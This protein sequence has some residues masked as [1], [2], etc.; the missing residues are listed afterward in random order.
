M[1]L[2]VGQL[3]LQRQIGKAK[4]GVVVADRSQGAGLGTELV[5]RRF[6]SRATKKSAVE[7]RILSENGAK[8][9]LAKHFHFD[10]GADGDRPSL[11]ATHDFDAPHAAT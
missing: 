3:I 1:R 10:C 7:A 5:R 2:G 8:L 11:I 9:A 6:T 4:L